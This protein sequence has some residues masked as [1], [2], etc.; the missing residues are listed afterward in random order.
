MNKTFILLF[1]CFHIFIKSQETST[2]NTSQ[3]PPAPGYP[4]DRKLPDPYKGVSVH[5]APKDVVGKMNLEKVVFQPDQP[6]EFPG[7]IK[8]LKQKIYETVDPYN[9]TDFIHWGTVYI[10]INDTGKIADIFVQT[11]SNNLKAEMKTALEKIKTRW[12][13]AQRKGM[14]VNSLVSFPVSFNFNVE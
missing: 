3:L 11:A 10:I 5:D 2:D 13:P 1:A 4:A 14:R 8:A 9:L 12:K 6:A 7:G